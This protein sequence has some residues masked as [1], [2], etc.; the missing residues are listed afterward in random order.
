MSW[1]VVSVTLKGDCTAAVDVSAAVGAV[2]TAAAA[3]AVLMSSRDDAPH[4]T[5]LSGWRGLHAA[6]WRFARDPD[7]WRCC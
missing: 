5:L 1:M 6:F 2:T 4:E 3:A 7:P